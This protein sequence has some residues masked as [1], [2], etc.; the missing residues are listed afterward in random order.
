MR[1]GSLIISLDFELYWGVLDRVPAARYADR[2]RTVHEAIPRM[3]ELFVEHNIHATWATVGF[4]L[5]EGFDELEARRPRIL[6]GYSNSAFCPYSYCERPASTE[7]KLHFAP[8]LAKRILAT[9]G[10]ELGT[11]TFS[12]FYCLEEPRSLEA[13]RVDLG[14]AIDLVYEKYGVRTK[15]LVFPRN[16]YSPQHIQIAGELGIQAF[17]GNPEH[18]MYRPR[19]S[20]ENSRLAKGARLVDAYL[21]IAKRLLHV[22]DGGA[23]PVDIRASR[24]LRPW[25]RR[26][27]HLESLKHWR[28]A[29]EMEVAARTGR[30]YHLW[31]HPHNFGADLQENLAGLEK[32]LQ[33]YSKLRDS[34][35]MNSLTMAEA[36]E[37]A[38]KNF[39]AT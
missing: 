8:D 3:L 33:T 16:Q 10:Q 27:R 6:P 30:Q 11:H 39:Q 35:G 28:I 5:M 25:S 18:W 19:A 7:A 24:F 4:V 2:L 38:R 26:L 23:Y 21:P 20:T 36:A 17:R 15:S 12:H 37:H 34:F 9:P 32:I 1:V 14:A 13:F 22:P 31:W 29:S